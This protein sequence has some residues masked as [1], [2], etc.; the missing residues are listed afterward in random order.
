MFGQVTNSCPAKVMGVTVGWIQRCSVNF[1]LWVSSSM[2]WQNASIHAQEWPFDWFSCHKCS[3]AKRRVFFVPHWA[4]QHWLHGFKQSKDSKGNF[5]LI[6]MHFFVTRHIVV[7]QRELH[8]LVVWFNLAHMNPH[9]SN[10]WL[11]GVPGKK[12]ALW[13]TQ[14]VCFIVQLSFWNKNLLQ[15]NMTPVLQMNFFQSCKRIHSKQSK[16]TQWK[17]SKT[18]QEMISL[19]I[20]RMISSPWKPHSNLSAFTWK[21]VTSRRF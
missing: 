4:T 2:W 1:H 11:A 7:A 20:W 18:V 12:V 16:K 15:Q 17:L 8:K 19:S 9:I 14:I 10:R 21:N 3:S 13:V 5:G 6:L